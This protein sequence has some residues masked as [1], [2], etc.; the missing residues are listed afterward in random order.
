MGKHILNTKHMQVA[1]KIHMFCMLLGSITCII[2]F[3]FSISLFAKLDIVECF[4]GCSLSIMAF[5]DAEKIGFIT[6][7]NCIYYFFAGLLFVVLQFPILIA[8]FKNKTW[9]IYS[10]LCI[11][12]TDMIFLLLH[13][14]YFTDM[15]SMNNRIGYVIASI[16]FKLIGI[17]FLSCW[18]YCS[19]NK[20]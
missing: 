4:S 7:E 20:A 12:I 17:I 11:Y 5:P 18:I 10:A 3:P 2:L 13:C 16:V 14:F 15:L 19:K 8:I 1:C 6:L 9:G